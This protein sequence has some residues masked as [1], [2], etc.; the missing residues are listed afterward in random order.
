[1]PGIGSYFAACTE[2]RDQVGKRVIGYVV[3]N[4]T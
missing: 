2:T 1:M 4:S 3:S